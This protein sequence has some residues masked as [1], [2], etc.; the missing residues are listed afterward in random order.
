MTEEM[1]AL[2]ESQRLKKPDKDSFYVYYKRDRVLSKYI[3]IL[4]KELELRNMGYGW[5]IESLWMLHQNIHI[6]CDYGLRV[7]NEEFL[8]GIINNLKILIAY[9][10]PGSEART[11]KSPGIL[12]LPELKRRLIEILSS[13]KQVYNIKEQ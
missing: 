6:D 10:N 12:Y 13:L 5:V 7:I 3:N 8:S 9:L 11:G 1:V 2:I 4:D